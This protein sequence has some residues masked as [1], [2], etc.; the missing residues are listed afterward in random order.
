[1]DTYMPSIPEINTDNVKLRFPYQHLTKIQG[2]PEY[3]KM[4]I[5]REEMYCNALSIKFIFGGGKRGHKGL[6][7]KLTIYRIETGEDWVVPETGIVYQIFSANATENAKKQ[8]I[9]EFISRDTNIE[10]SK[11]VEE[12]IKN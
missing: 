7:T 11:L 10:M 5:V 1:M 12:Q 2:N 9:T 8:L 3:E 4:C 6:V